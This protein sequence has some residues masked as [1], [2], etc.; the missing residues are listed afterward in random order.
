VVLGGV[1]G[2]VGRRWGGTGSALDGDGL[3]VGLRWAGGE[4]GLEMRVGCGV[5]MGFWGG[6]V[7]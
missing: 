1:V 2:A 6:V 4:G 5:R 7:G 3:E